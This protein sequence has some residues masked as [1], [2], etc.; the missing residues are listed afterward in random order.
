MKERRGPLTEFCSASMEW[1]YGPKPNSSSVDFL[2]LQSSVLSP[3]STVLSP[4]P[5]VLSPLPSSII[6][7]WRLDQCLRSATLH[8]STGSIYKILPCSPPEFLTLTL[9][10][11][12]PDHVNSTTSTL[13]LF[14][15]INQMNTTPFFLFQY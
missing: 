3:Q 14:I 13:Q 4:Q 10:L 6:V 2:P 9:Y 8:L 15:L 5:S 12:L 7:D 1:E 11:D